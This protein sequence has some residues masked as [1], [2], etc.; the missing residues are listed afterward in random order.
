MYSEKVESAM[1]GAIVALN[2][3]E[4]QPPGIVDLEH[5]SIL[6]GCVSKALQCLGR[7]CIALL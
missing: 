5:A 1:G 7:P 3:Q 2:R 6:L 4:L